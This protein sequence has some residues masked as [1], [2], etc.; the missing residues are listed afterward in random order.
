[1]DFLKNCLSLGYNESSRWCHSRRR[2]RKEVTTGVARKYE[3]TVW[4]YKVLLHLRR[5]QVSSKGRRQGWKEKKIGWDRV[6][7]ELDGE[8]NRRKSGCSCQDCC[9]ENGN[10]R[11]SLVS[12]DILPDNDLFFY[13]LFSLI[14]SIWLFQRKLFLNI[15]RLLFAQ[16]QYSCW[17]TGTGSPRTLSDGL[18][19]LS[20]PQY[21]MI[22]YGS[23]LKVVNIHLRVRMEEFLTAWRNS[24]CIWAITTSLW[25]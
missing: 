9:R 7:S 15:F 14:L 3:E 8:V 23:P 2:I 18:S 6:E 11:N 19:F 5:N 17:I 24:L 22:L 25:N 20:L 13:F 12:V 4:I 1:M 10:E 16:L 21:S